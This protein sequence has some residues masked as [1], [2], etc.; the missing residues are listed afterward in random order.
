MHSVPG[1]IH[2]ASSSESSRT[3]VTGRT[4]WMC[5]PP[6]SR[7]RHRICVPGAQCAAARPASSRFIAPPSVMSRF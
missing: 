7:Y 1:A 3:T 6:F 2:T 5:A 4:I